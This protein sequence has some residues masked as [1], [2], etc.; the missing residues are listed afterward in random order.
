[1]SDAARAVDD[2]ERALAGADYEN[3]ASSEAEAREKAGSAYRAAQDKA[4]AAGAEAADAESAVASAQANVDA[5]EAAY[6]DAAASNPKYDA[7]TVDG[8]L[9]Y[10]SSGLYD[11]RKAQAESRYGA[12]AVDGTSLDWDYLFRS[13]DMIDKLNEIRNA[14]GLS[15]L[16][17]SGKLMADQAVEAD[18]NDR[19]N[20]HD[21]V[22]HSEISQGQALCLAWGYGNSGY[23]SY[24]T[25][26]NG[27][28]TAWKDGGWMGEQ[29]IYDAAKSALGTGGGTFSYNGRSY[30]LPNGWQSMANYNLYRAAPDFYL[31]TGH[32]LNIL[33]GNP[34]GGVAGF[35]TS[36]YRGANRYTDA[37]AV[38]TVMS[39]RDDTVLSVADFRALAKR[40]QAGELSESE[41]AKAAA[42]ALDQAKA[43]LAQAQAALADAQAAKAE[44]DAAVAE[45]K[46]AY[47]A[48]DEAYAKAMNVSEEEWT[49]PYRA[50]LAEAQGDLADARAKAAEAQAGLDAAQAKGAEAQNAFARAQSQA[51]D[52]GR[53]AT[54]AQAEAAAA[55]AA[56]KAKQQAYGEAVAQAAASKAS[57]DAARDA[58]QSALAGE[59]AAQQAVDEAQQQLNGARARLA[60]ETLK[61]ENAAATLQA[62]KDKAAASEL[63]AQNAADAYRKAQGTAETAQAE[64]AAR[65]K[66]KDEY[67]AAAARATE[68]SKTADDLA[69]QASALEA[70]Q[71]GLDASAANLRAKAAALGSIAQMVKAMPGID[72]VLKAP[73]ALDTTIDALESYDAG[74]GADAEAVEAL[75]Q[76]Y[77]SRLRNAKASASEAI[78]LQAAV[79]SDAHAVNAARNDLAKA[80]AALD[81]ANMRVAIDEALDAT[82]SR[83][84]ASRAATARSAT[85]A[86][87]TN[88]AD[89]RSGK[90]ARATAVPARQAAGGQGAAAVS[91]EMPKLGDEPSS[92]PLTT[93]LLGALAAGFALK[94][95]KHA[96]HERG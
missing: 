41:E 62:A 36:R 39:T 7:A 31:A 1:M 6:E 52:L 26:V 85:H 61:E 92:L 32:Y 78:A 11:T 40:A 53:K 71:A 91:G 55:Q 88:R 46:A 24:G 70:A 44:A 67:D 14:Y 23:S 77:A 5:A 83:D 33:M 51:D 54:A 96:R 20:S 81:D 73:G 94:R 74:E 63:A 86:A 27:D 68:L 56:A 93:G 12:G 30:T 58:Y 72:E 47:D 50:A 25:P 35:G 9:N 65:Q 64:F 3:R 2:A 48:A 90:S 18:I 80:Q 69:S 95:G 82:F 4:A 28:L 45:A 84:S 60:E 38:G 57:A 87:P 43:E 66:A 49:A 17:V 21:N 76:G 8:F 19:T 79:D 59:E 89:A 15:T 42:T 34:Y 22:G 37:L 75:A 10:V 16:K 13:L 29:L